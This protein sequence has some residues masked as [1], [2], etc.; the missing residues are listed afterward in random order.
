M[1]LTNKTGFK[2][3][4]IIVALT[5]VSKCTGFLREM[6]VASSFGTNYQTDAYFMSLAIPNIVFNIIAVVVTATL[7]PKFGEVIEKDG[8]E[9][10][11]RFASNL[12][13]ISLITSLFILA[14]LETM[15]PS[16]IK[17]IA[18]S[19][20]KE[21]F[22]LTIYLSRISVIGIVFMTLSALVLAILQSVDE[23]ISPTISGFAVNIP[24]I[25]Y[26]FI[27][28]DLT[29]IELTVATL[30]GYLFQVVIQVPWLL[31]NGFR[32]K[33]RINI[34]DTRLREMA[35]LMVP[36]FFGIGANQINF[37]VNRA[38]A[39]SLPEGSVSSYNYA[40]VVNGVSYG[41][42]VS[43]FVMLYYSRISRVACKYKQEA[44]VKSLLESAIT[45]IN[46]FMFPITLAI[47]GMSKEFIS[48]LFERGAFNSDSV[49]TT[50]YILQFLALGMLFN[51]MR[52]MFDRTFYAFQNPKTPVIIGS[53]GVVINIIMNFIFVPIYG[54]GGLA[55]SLSVASIIS[56]IIL[57][58]LMK[59]Q[60]DI[61]NYY[62]IFGDTLKIFFSAL[63]MIIFVLCIN[64]FLKEM[65][66]SNLTILFFSSIEGIIFYSIFLL[67]FKVEIFVYMVDKMYCKFKRL[68][69]RIGH[70]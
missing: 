19:F 48:A 3:T 8:R 12:F 11:N 56:C 61:E 2:A 58:I 43:C 13:W 20:N 41:I 37:I 5:I 47:I 39:S 63:L 4:L 53:F 64:T 49:D 66:L 69:G 6:I 26:V 42:F 18:P 14:I 1:K 17:I 22:E 60:L 21:T 68:R 70:E 52:D 34:N 62:G 23:Y 50:A 67:L 29:I 36:A 59:K 44:V 28:T 15:L 7:I 40:N 35:I 38:M 65:N 51:G 46:L 33:K 25:F 45:K 32:L 31:S 9:E 57:A 54:I 30:I 24:I 27:C 10:F 55:L 16:L